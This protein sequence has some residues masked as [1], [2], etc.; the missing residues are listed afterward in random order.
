MTILFQFR[1]HEAILSEDRILLKK[2]WEK[3]NISSQSYLAV[4]DGELLTEGDT[5][6]DGDRIQMISVISGGFQ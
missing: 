4:R 5:L 6:A 2:V 3:L 1:D